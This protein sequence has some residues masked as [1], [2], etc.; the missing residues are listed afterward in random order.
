MVL[1]I[2]VLIQVGHNNG[3]HPCTAHAECPTGEFCARE[4]DGRSQ[5]NASLAALCTALV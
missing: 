4:H 1:Q 3:Q 5:A 2:F